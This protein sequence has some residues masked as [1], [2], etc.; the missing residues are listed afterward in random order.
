[1]PDPAVGIEPFS[2]KNLLN[3]PI[4]DIKVYAQRY[5]EDNLLIDL[6][7][8]KCRTLLENMK[9]WHV[10]WQLDLYLPI[11]DTD[12][13]RKRNVSEVHGRD[14]QA[15]CP[16]DST[17][18]CGILTAIQNARNNQGASMSVQSWF[19]DFSEP[20]LHWSATALDFVNLHTV[21]AASGIVDALEGNINFYSF[22][23]TDCYRY[24]QRIYLAESEKITSPQKSLSEPLSTALAICRDIDML[25]VEKQATYWQEHDPVTEE[26]WEK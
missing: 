11:S 3:H 9:R 13:Q 23:F 21:V 26:K 22:N 8:E 4:E 14:E 2:D 24:S 6:Q 25:Y 20:S 18:T 17:V 1:V 10:C 19:L 5:I 12:K 7:S 15:D 16:L